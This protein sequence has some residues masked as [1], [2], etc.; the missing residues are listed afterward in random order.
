MEK[1]D[2]EIEREKIGSEGGEP[3]VPVVRRDAGHWQVAPRPGC[4]VTISR[5]VCVCVQGT[6]ERFRRHFGSA[7]AVSGHWPGGTEWAVCIYMLCVCVCLCVLH[8]AVACLTGLEV[9]W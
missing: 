9:T 2:A 4:P 1:K 8:Y 7:G 6:E 3:V 5:S